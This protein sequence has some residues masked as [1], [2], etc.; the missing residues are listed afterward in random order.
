MIISVNIGYAGPLSSG[1]LSAFPQIFDQFDSFS[2][3]VQLSRDPESIDAF[4]N[5]AEIHHVTPSSLC[6][7]IRIDEPTEYWE[8]R[9]H[10]INVREYRKKWEDKYGKW[11]HNT[12]DW[13]LKN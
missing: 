13:P 4:W 1:I 2:E 9:V 11:K 7:Y 8:Y 6:L 5:W 12:K 10:L 3:F